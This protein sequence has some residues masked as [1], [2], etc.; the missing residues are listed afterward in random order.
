ML[1]PPNIVV[2][3][4]ENLEQ[5]FDRVHEERFHDIVSSSIKTEVSFKEIRPEYPHP[6][7]VLQ[8]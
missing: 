3:D 1:P 4:A 6:R 8:Q 2:D 7:V 5:A